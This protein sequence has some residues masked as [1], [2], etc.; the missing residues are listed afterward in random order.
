MGSREDDAYWNEKYNSTPGICNG[1]YPY[2]CGCA[3]C[4]GKPYCVNCGGSVDD[5]DQCAECD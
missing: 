3:A 5:N 2:S 4:E 1:M